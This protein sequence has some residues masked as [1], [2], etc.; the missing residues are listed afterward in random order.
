MGHDVTVLTTKKIAK[1]HDLRLDCS[2]FKTIEVENVIRSYLLSRCYKDSV[3]ESQATRDNKKGLLARLNDVF[4][5]KGILTR[6]VRLP[7]FIDLWYRAACKIASSSN[8]D[9]TVSTFSPYVNHL[10][11]KKLKT[12]NKTKLWIADY[13]D[14]WTQNHIFKGLYPFTL[15]EEYLESKVNR[16]ADLIT[17]VSEPLASQISKKYKLGNVKVIMNGFDIDDLDNLSKDNYWTDSKIRLVYTGSIYV[18]QDP[19]PL[20]EA[21]RAIRFSEHAYLLDNLEVIFIGAKAN[22]DDLV[23]KYSVHKWVKYN[24]VLPREDSLRMQRDAHALIFLE[25]EAPGVDGILTGKLFEYLCSGTQILGIGVTNTSSSGK[26]I[27]DSGH[28]VNL[29]KDIN[30]IVEYLVELLRSGTK[31]AVDIDNVYLINNSRK[32]QAER[33][34]DLATALDGQVYE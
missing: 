12:Q 30:R 15:L 26:L 29:G 22:L 6:D 19:S 16:L 8:W 21:I 7:N 10:V 34:I 11:A 13:R 1:K 28:G 27:F 2:S 18:G 14:L 23:E 32:A 4:H 17:T 9:L 20:F 24:G 5:K 33:M 25:Y 3:P 31:K